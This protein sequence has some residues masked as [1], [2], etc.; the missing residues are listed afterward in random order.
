[1]GYEFPYGNTLDENDKLIK[2]SEADKTGE[3]Y[4]KEKTAGRK[5]SK[6]HNSCYVSTAFI[7]IFSLVILS[8]V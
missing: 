8:K 4:L 6:K 2:N 5:K 7:E 3:Q 1:M